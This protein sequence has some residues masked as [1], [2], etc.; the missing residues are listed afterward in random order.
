MSIA[1]QP[2]TGD[3]RMLRIGIPSKSV[4]LFRSVVKLKMS[5]TSRTS[6]TSSASAF[7]VSRICICLS[8]GSAINTWSAFLFA[9]TRFRSLNGSTGT[10]MI[11]LP[12][13]SSRSSRYAATCI[14]VQG[15]LRM[16]S[17]SVWPSFPAPT[18]SARRMFLGTIQGRMSRRSART[19]TCAAGTAAPASPPIRRIP[20]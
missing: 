2:D 5:G 1:F 6:T 16:F 17:W 7:I 11:V 9:M 13:R 8:N 10:P 12:A 19:R 15:F 18:I 4:T 14:P 3:S 20:I